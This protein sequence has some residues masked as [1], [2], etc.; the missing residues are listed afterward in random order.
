MSHPTENPFHHPN[1]MISS[2][3]RDLPDHR[4][5]AKDACLRTSFFPVMMEQSPASPRDAVTESLRL[6]ESAPVYI[7]IYAHR[8]G[9][10]PDDDAVNPNRISVTEM[11]Y[12]RAKA[13][14]KERLIF[15]M[16]DDHPLKSGDIDKGDKAAKLQAF[17]DRVMGENIVQFF[18][19]PEDLRAHIVQSLAQ[20]EHRLKANAA[21]LHRD[22]DIPAA[23]EPYIAHPY[24]LLSASQLVGRQRELNLLTDWVAKPSSPLYRARMLHIVAI[25][26]M[27]KSALTWKWFTEI[28]PLEM[29]SLA[30]RI[31]WS[32]YESDAHFENFV[33]RTLAYVSG[34]PRAVITQ[35]PPPKREQ[36]LIDHLN[37][38]PFLLVLDGLERI[39]IAYAKMD[40]A[41]LM[42]DDIDERTA[43]RVAGAWGL[44]ESAAQSFIGQHQLRKTADVRAGQFLRKLAGVQQSRILVSTRLYPADVQTIIGDPMPGCFAVFLPGL[45]DD[46]AVDL[47]RR[48]G[49]SGT[50]EH[51]L[52]LFKQ[53]DNYPLLIRALAGEVARYRRAP[54]DF[55][56]WVTHNPDFGRVL[57]NLRSEDRKAHVMDYALRGLKPAEKQVL[58]TIAAFRMPATYTTLAALFVS[59]GQ[60]KS[61]SKAHENRP[62][63]PPGDAFAPLS[64]F[65]EGSGEGSAP[66]LFKSEPELDA[67]LDT[68]EDRGLVGWDRIANRY[69]LHPIVRAVTWGGVNADQ[70]RGIYSTISDH[71]TPLSKNVPDYLQ[72]E[73]YDD[74][75][76]AVELYNAL[77]GMGQYDA[78]RSLFRERIDDATLYRLSAARQRVDLLE[79]LF[80]DGVDQ[81]PRLTDK[82]LQGGTLNALAQGYQFIGQPGSAVSLFRL[83][84]VMADELGNKGDLAVG[85]RNLADAARLSGSLRLSESSARRAL[86]LSREAQARFDEALSLDRLGLARLARAGSAHRRGLARGRDAHDPV[87]AEAGAALRR[88]LQPW[89]DLSIKQGEGFINAFLS[90]WA[91]AG[92]DHAV[93]RIYADRAWELAHIER[94]EGDFIRAAVRQGQAALA[95]ND[96][97]TA[98]ERLHHA[99]VR[100][101]AVNDAENELPALIALARLALV[102]GDVPLA[103]ELL[104][105][106]WE[107]AERGPYPMFHADALNLLAEIERGAGNRDQAVEAAAKAYTFAW[108]DGI[109]RDGQEVWAYMRGL[110]AAKRHLI[111]LG[112]SVPTLPPFDPSAWEPLP[113]VEIDPPDADA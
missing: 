23:P 100:A 73:S 72:V 52:H 28:A 24:V 111:A 61:R 54:G 108:C 107:G 22:T 71:F 31:W 112:A 50:R 101:R 110:N 36:Q 109:S 92:G 49:V 84:A 33:I 76:P 14:G 34:Q 67:V 103:R 89:I 9:F 46:D 51:L 60:G 1:A 66:K 64:E 13:L 56:E 12:N 81:P 79:R 83:G 98:D 2:T 39:L 8:Y 45:T 99:L 25:G 7:G 105:Q 94:Y 38:K 29:P 17:K 57:A 19:S 26:G 58:D 37:A 74:L 6:V 85:L 53:F 82:R 104:D 78:A 65:G 20:S 48:M 42:D 21:A 59:D 30:G 4:E 47:W 77:V 91:L 41:H 11:E 43:N 63:S 97:S 55:D 69:D 93:A 86:I 113:E 10:V 70:Q 106:V 27:G 95:L 90:E 87:Y 96:L 44:P 18:K 62:A 68:L 32:F 15:V 102:R 40:A 5:Q 35:L 80:P 75:T 88:S 3:I 16:H